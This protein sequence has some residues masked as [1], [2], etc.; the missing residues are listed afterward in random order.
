MTV[1]AKYTPASIEQAI[2]YLQRG[3]VVAVPTE[4]V[5]GLVADATS[6][7]AVTHFYNVKGRAAGKPSQILVSGLEVAEA[8]ATFPAGA[9]ALAK[10]FWPGALTL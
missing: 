7:E 1:I 6:E 2:A 3:E 8:I 5:Y 4:T 10:C 9:A